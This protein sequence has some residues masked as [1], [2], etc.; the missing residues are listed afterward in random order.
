MPEH[1]KFNW[2]L[3]PPEPPSPVFGQLSVGDRITVRELA[4]L[5]KN[6]PHQIVADLM[7]H[8]VLATPNDPVAPDLVAKVVRRYG[9]VAKKV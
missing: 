1:K 9:Y 2:A 4:I 5:L 8:G 6:P 7:E 3:R